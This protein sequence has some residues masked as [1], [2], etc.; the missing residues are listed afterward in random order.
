MLYVHHH[1][2]FHV[3]PVINV[4]KVI[5]WFGPLEGQSPSVHPDHRVLAGEQRSIL[6]PLCLTELSDLNFCLTAGQSVL[7]TGDSGCGKSSLLRVI[8]ALWSIKQGTSD[9]VYSPLCSVALWSAVAGSIERFVTHGHRGIMYLP[10]KPH[11]TDGSLRQLV[12][13]SLLLCGSHPWNVTSHPLS[14][15]PDWTASVVV[16]TF[17]RYGFSSTKKKSYTVFVILNMHYADAPF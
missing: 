15:M 2:Q 9:D 7:V 6:V 1:W 16:V 13:S 10:Q 17:M 5:A 4:P 3:D 11:L 12:S 8:G 14:A